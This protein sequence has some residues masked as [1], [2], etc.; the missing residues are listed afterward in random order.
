MRGLLLVLLFL[1]MFLLGVMV[2]MVD[3]YI[4]NAR[5][6]STCNDS[7]SVVPMSRMCAYYGQ[8]A[9]CI[10]KPRLVYTYFSHRYVACVFGKRGAAWDAP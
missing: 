9:K 3:Q 10:L 1:S 7:V 4:Y 5:T 2:G 6:S 8:D